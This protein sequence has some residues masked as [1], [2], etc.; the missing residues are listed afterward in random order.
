M[1]VCVAEINGRAVAAFN[2][3]NEIQADGRASSK[4]FRGDLTVLENEGQ[5]LWN[6]ADEILVRKALPAEEAQFGASQA[7]AIKDKE[8]DV[9]DHWLMFLVPV[10]DPTGDFDPYDAPGAEQS[11]PL[12]FDKSHHTPLIAQRCSMRQHSCQRSVPD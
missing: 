10:T 1:T 11:E 6:G 12:Q 4:P 9:D 8:I 5:P 7:R 3:E 2:A